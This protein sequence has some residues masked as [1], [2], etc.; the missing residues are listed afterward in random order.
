MMKVKVG[1]SRLSV[2]DLTLRSAQILPHLENNPH[3]PHLPY[4][5]EEMYAERQQLIEYQ[6]EVQSGNYGMRLLRDAVQRDLLHHVDCCAQ[7]VNLVAKGDVEILV[8]SGFELRSAR[9]TP[10]LPPQ[11]S[12]IK[13][14][15]HIAVG[16]VKVFW[17]GVRSRKYYK[18]ECTN[19]PSDLTSWKDM[20]TS[21][22]THTIISKLPIGQYTY[23][24]VAAV[25]VKGHGEWSNEAKLMVG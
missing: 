1:L 7:Y 18:V 8:T 25:N 23:F 24:R 12:S 5:T 3:F 11:I 14:V 6:K 2:A 22:E 21:T 9:Q 17:K 10:E 19:D 13:V 4:T 16:S 20:A 15:N